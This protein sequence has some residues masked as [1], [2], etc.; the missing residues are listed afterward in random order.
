MAQPIRAVGRKGGL[1]IKK[2]TSHLFTHIANTFYF[3][4]VDER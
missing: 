2:K 1:I 4:I 3:N